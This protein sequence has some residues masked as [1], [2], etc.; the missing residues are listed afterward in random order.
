MRMGERVVQTSERN[1]F[2][3][4][5][6]CPRPIRAVPNNLNAER[7][8]QNGC[9]A[10]RWLKTHLFFSTYTSTDGFSIREQSFFCLW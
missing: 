3:F 4:S 6:C 7:L 10:F 8:S 1:E 9:G 2:V 5:L